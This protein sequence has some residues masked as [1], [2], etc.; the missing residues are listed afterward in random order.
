[1]NSGPRMNFKAGVISLRHD[2]SFKKIIFRISRG[3]CIVLSFPFSKIF[4]DSSTKEEANKLVFFL[5][6]E[7]PKDGFFDQKLT[8][9]LT[10]YSSCDYLLPESIQELED[11]VKSLEQSKVEN[12]NIAE[13]NEKALNDYLTNIKSSLSSKNFTKIESHK[14]YLIKEREIYNKLIEMQ[15]FTNFIQADVF[16]LRSQIGKLQK[17]FQEME[18]HSHCPSGQLIESKEG[19]PPSYFVCN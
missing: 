10:S 7:G 18:Q 17:A 2:E 9:V 4:Q 12:E 6:Y 11:Q 8:K 15:L 1:M 19:Q 3:N 14:F 13:L 16:I 5:V